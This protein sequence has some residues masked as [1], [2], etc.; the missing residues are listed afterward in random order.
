MEWSATHRQPQTEH[1]SDKLA[2]AQN[3]NNAI[4]NPAWQHPATVNPFHLSTLLANVGI[5]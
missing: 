2:P 3:S 1:A 4:L 5:G